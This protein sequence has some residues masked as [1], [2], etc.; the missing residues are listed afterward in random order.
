MFPGNEA[1]TKYSKASESVRKDVECFFGVLKG[2]CRI[3]KLP[4]LCRKKESM[5]QRV[6]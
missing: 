2:R 5:Q 6:F 3:L 1:E 4:T